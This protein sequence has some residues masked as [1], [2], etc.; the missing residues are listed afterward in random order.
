MKQDNVRPW[1][2]PENLTSRALQI[3]V[4]SFPIVED[5]AEVRFFEQK[6]GHQLS[7]GGKRREDPGYQF[8]QESI[9]KGEC[10]DV[11]Q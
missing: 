3:K 8:D 9:R 5:S 7:C 4:P 6:L 11:F 2:H 10:I 1:M